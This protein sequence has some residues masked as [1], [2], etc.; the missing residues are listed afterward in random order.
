MISKVISY[1]ITGLEV[2]K[3]AIEVFVYKGLPST[4]IVGLPD[5]AIKESKE[6]VRAAI[7]NCG[8][9]YP[10]QRII[11]NLSPADIKKEG[12]SF[13]LA[14]A[15]GILAGT[16][17]IDEML[18]RDYA[19]LGELSLDGKIRAI[20]GSLPITMAIS[21][22]EFK[23]L[24]LPEFNCREAAM[25]DNIDILPARHLK[26]VIHFLNST[27]FIKPYTIDSSSLLQN[28]RIYNIDFNDVKGQRAVKRGLE[29][30]SSGGHNTL[31]I[32]PPGSGKTMLAK[33]IPTILPDMTLEESLETTKIHS[34]VG[35][36]PPETGLIATRP[37][38]S[39]HHTASDVALVG[40]GS[41]PKPGEITLS[42][43]GILFLDELPEFNRR[44]IESL[45]QPLEDHYVTVSRASKTLRFPSKF[46]L[47]CSMNPCPCGWYTDPKKECHCSPAQIQKYM[48]K[49]SGPLL[50]RI[51]IHLEV[52]A[53]KSTELLYNVETE[54][55][56]DIKKRTTAARK[57]QEKRFE[58]TSIFANAHMTQKM[59]RHFCSLS[60]E[61]KAL[62]KMAIEELG[63]SARAHD[64]ILKVARTIADLEETENIQPNH[65]SEAI[66]YRSLDRGWWG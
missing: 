65:I 13:D 36:I 60:K 44:T 46:M 57:I 52:P 14:I 28:S 47:V 10:S 61:S 66:Q 17:Q 15:L 29:V 64:K 40:G 42:H 22:K 9:K 2:Y 37:F 53:L 35:L 58:T 12:P 32:G 8:Y 50:D 7:K 30:A 25:T 31:L 23:G 20:S 6:R 48:T 5:N 38:R 54:S 3:V 26:E 59:I 16:G 19:F 11:I 39:P 4:T 21:H 62:L 18:L 51:D 41:I 45:R 55:S 1:G 24:I 43:N 27:N 49:I 34:I 63:L 33:R 56:K